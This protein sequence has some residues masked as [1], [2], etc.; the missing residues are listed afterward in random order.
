M[1]VWRRIARIQLLLPS[2]WTAI[3]I[4]SKRLQDY[5]RTRYQ[6]QR[7]INRWP[8]VS[9]TMILSHYPSWG[10]QLARSL[11]LYDNHGNSELPSF[12]NPVPHD[13][14][15]MVLA[16]SSLQNRSENMIQ[17]P[18]R[19]LLLQ[20]WH[21]AF[22]SLAWSGLYL[23]Y[24]TI[25]PRV[26]QLVQYCGVSFIS[27]TSACLSHLAGM[28]VFSL[29]GR[30]VYHWT[31][32]IGLFTPGLEELTAGFAAEFTSGMFVTQGI[33][34]GIGAP[35]SFFISSLSFT[36]SSSPALLSITST[37]SQTRMALQYSRR[38][39]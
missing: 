38:R 32:I 23:W 16:L 10:S 8:H 7:S 20:C 15:C 19:L 5:Y 24:R 28:L 33:L 13:P 26:F 21:N 1:L 4:F 39:I 37:G 18:A 27:C 9:C 34:L 30:F 25:S 12:S 22:V 17:T 3:Q 36:S 2:A 35:F 31:S 11:A 29:M 6:F 14:N